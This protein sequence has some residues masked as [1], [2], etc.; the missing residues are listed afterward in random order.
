MNNQIT[1]GV[2]T[3]GSM[4]TLTFSQLGA[5]DA[6]TYS[7]TATLGNASQSSMLNVAV[8]SEFCKLCNVVHDLSYLQVRPSLSVLLLM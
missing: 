5:S 8:D 3:T 6:G 1:S 2:V 7:C 4:S